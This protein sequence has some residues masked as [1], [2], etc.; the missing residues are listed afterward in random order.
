M[1]PV[2]GE[3]RSIFGAEPL[4]AVDY[5][6]TLASLRINTLEKALRAI[7]IAYTACLAAGSPTPLIE[8]LAKAPIWPT[9]DGRF[10]PLAATLPL[11][12]KRP[13]E[14]VPWLEADTLHGDALELLEAYDA[15]AAQRW[16][17][18]LNGRLLRTRDEWLSQALA[19]A[20][21]RWSDEN[22]ET[23]GYDAL[24]LID[25]W[26][27]IPEFSEIAPLVEMPNDQSMRL[28]LA[29][30]ARVPTRKGWVASQNAYAG[31]EINGIPEL[32]SYFRD[33]PDRAIANAPVRAITAFG[34]KRWKALLRFLGVSWEPK[35]HF[36]VR[37]AFLPS[38]SSYAFH[39]A[40][41]SSLLHINQEWYI[42]HFPECLE[43]LSAPQIAACV[44]TL[45]TATQN[46]QGRWRKVSWADRAHAPDPFTSFADF[47]LKRE[48]YLPQRARAG[49]NGGRF[50]P[51]ELF[52]PGKGI[53]G[54]TPILDVGTINRIRRSGLKPIFVRRLH[55][56]DALPQDWRSWAE[57]SDGLLKRIDE[58]HRISTKS[59]RAFY[60]ALLRVPD[61]AKGTPALMRVAA[62][63]PDR[64]G[65]V[66]VANSADVIWIDNGR[67]ENQE[68]LNG[69][70]QK[71]KA[72]LPVRL[73]RGQGA[74]EVLGVRP[75]SEVLA[76][77]PRYESVSERRSREIER[78][79]IA[80]R[81]A[82]A[83]ICRTKNLYLKKL[84]VFEA[85][86]DLR[87]CISLDGEPLA[88]R[89]APS[90]REG[91]RWLI[92]LQ[93]GDRWEAVAAA[94]AEQFG[95]HGADL[96]YRFAR[97]LRAS[98]DEVAVILADDGIPQYQ[99]REALNDL[100]EQEDDDEPSN[101]DD[102]DADT[103]VA[104]G[105]SGGANPGDRSDDE[106]DEYTDEADEVDED[107]SEQDEGGNDRDGNGNGRKASGE[108]RGGSKR[109]QRRKL[110]GGGGGDE[111]KL[112]RRDA[113]EAAE[114]AAR[115]GLRA[116]AW[117]LRQIVNVLG[118]DW[119]C[120]ANVRD[121]DLRETDIL[122]TRGGDEF[123]I[124]VKSL[125][126]ERIY[127]SEL[128]RE[129]AENNSGRYFMALLVSDGDEDY[130]VR[131]LWDP[132]VDLAALPRRI[133]WLWHSTE[134]GPSVSDGWQ[135][136]S[137][138]RWPQRTADRYVHVVQVTQ[139]YLDTLDA[140]G[141]GLPR[142]VEHIT[143]R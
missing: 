108:R 17:P 21:A 65:D 16:A 142:L 141:G 4:R 139:E 33:V 125:A 63:Y 7:K 5:A 101:E 67:F 14:W 131:W 78:R 89:S 30:V 107:G 42:E 84:P 102:A 114:A 51:H 129:K 73:D 122:L 68:V 18:L 111:R 52:W 24:R 79:L 92:N 76:V 47:Q 117:L 57:W 29:S 118:K 8:K 6:A 86:N 82:L 74:P 31:R 93:S 56:R 143:V 2:F 10:R 49:M 91:A 106:G 96:K 70:G 1:L 41:G 28:T 59:V 83:A 132:L 61:R 38:R 55:V 121:D 3:L 58:G 105:E 97:I 35:I 87:L 130:L 43:L 71:G 140:D 48:R 94:T 12:R 104:D 137:G 44:G 133:E 66:I 40:T 109:L 13:S 80:R 26:A 77:A 45:A 25:E 126:S 75:A 46:L 100:D 112:R 124:E 99:I 22:W 72:I 138:I 115:N 11:L 134:E 135:L 123:H 39:R 37:D 120:S 81:G 136:E 54:I 53:A 23:S 64:D 36:L 98:R 62:T 20:L 19:P 128:E 113:A 69:L 103:P 119:S 85:V 88:D 34:A 27:T 32:A 95:L 50:A 9:D 60:D 110:F 127:W 116:E 90:F 15:T